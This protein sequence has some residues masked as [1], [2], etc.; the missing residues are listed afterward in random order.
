MLICDLSAVK[1]ELF[2]KCQRNQPNEFTKMIK[3][4]KFLQPR[5]DIEKIV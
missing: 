5:I 1:R 4:K 2:L 3:K